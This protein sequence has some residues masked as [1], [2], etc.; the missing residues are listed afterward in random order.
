MKLFEY[1]AKELFKE[2][3]IEIP[4]GVLIDKESDFRAAIAGLNA[5]YVLKS[6]LLSGKRGKAGLIRFA[7]SVEKAEAEA[8]SLFNSGHGVKKLLLV[9]L[10]ISIVFSLIKISDIYGNF[11][12]MLWERT[13]TLYAF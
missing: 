10:Q 5:P 3:G 6:Q 1:Q 12:W 2:A 13:F 7:D 11:I 9:I 4:K 8:K